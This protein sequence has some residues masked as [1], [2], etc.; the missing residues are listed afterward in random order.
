MANFIRR[1]V[2]NGMNLLFGPRSVPFTLFESFPALEPRRQG[3]IRRRLYAVLNYS[4]VGTQHTWPNRF[5]ELDEVLIQEINAALPVDELVHVHDMA[6]SNGITSVE[7]FERLIAERQKISVH[8]SDF[9]DAFYVVSP[10][11]SRWQVVFNRAL[12]PVQFVRGNYAISAGRLRMKIAH[13]A[14]ETWLKLSV[15]PSAIRILSSFLHGPAGGEGSELRLCVKTISL[16]H[17][18]CQ[19]LAQADCRFT[20]GRDDL[21]A[22]R[23]VPAHVVRLMNG[24]HPALPESE[25]RKALAGIYRTLLDDGIFMIGTRTPRERGVTIFRRSKRGFVAIRDIDGGS[26]WRGTIDEFTSGAQ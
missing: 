7:L 25:V 8:A 19:E 11:Q 15:L 20:Y 1:S 14:L 23:S 3:K 12:A 2:A 9:F 24:L 22:P 4:S 16:F 17:P 5:R 18:R 21:Y 6:A 13:R 26:F 10:P